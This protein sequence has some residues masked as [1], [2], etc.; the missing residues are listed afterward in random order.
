MDVVVLAGLSVRVNSATSSRSKAP[1]APEDTGSFQHNVIM[2][3]Y[4]PILK[5]CI[6]RKLLVKLTKYDAF[7]N[8][9]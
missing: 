7:A 9:W 4:I 3:Q 5:T 6:L 1:N 2:G 8:Y